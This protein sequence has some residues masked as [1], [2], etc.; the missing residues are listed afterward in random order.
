M[1]VPV[2]LASL[3]SLLLIIFNDT[4]FKENRRV[5]FGRHISHNSVCMLFKVIIDIKKTNSIQ[6]ETFSKAS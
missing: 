6:K 4:F 3:I 5:T 1:I 2:L